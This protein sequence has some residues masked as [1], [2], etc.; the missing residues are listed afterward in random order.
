MTEG[1]LRESGKLI[2]NLDD[3]DIIEMID[4]VKNGKSP[5]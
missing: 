4:L 1:I 3:N 2:I 5:L